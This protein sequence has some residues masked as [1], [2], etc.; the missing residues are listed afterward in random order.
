MAEGFPTGEGHDY[1]A[2][3]LWKDEEEFQDVLYYWSSWFRAIHM[4]KLSKPI[5]TKFKSSWEWYYGAEVFHQ[6]QS[7]LI[8]FAKGFMITSIGMAV[9]HGHDV[10]YN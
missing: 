2:N 3:I 5:E 9:A 1:A 8:C 6:V 4:A 7:N 10:G